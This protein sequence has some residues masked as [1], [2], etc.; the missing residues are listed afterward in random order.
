MSRIITLCSG[1]ARAGKTHLAV[2]LALEMVRRGHNTALFNETGSRS[3]IDD[4]LVL[5]QAAMLQRR[6]SDHGYL[7]VRR[8]YLGVDILS[9]GIPLSQWNCA[10]EQDVSKSIADMDCADGYDDFL[11]D[12]SAMDPCTLLACCRASALV[13]LVV[14]PDIRCHAETF[15]LI[16]ILQLN[17][18]QGELSLLYNKVDQAVD[19]NELHQTFNS[20]LRQYLGLDVPLL[21]MLGN[22]AH[23]S[24]A[25]RARQA[26]TSLFPDAE[27]SNQIVAIA[28][29]IDALGSRAAADEKALPVYWH[30]VRE[31]LASPVALPGGVFLETPDR[32]EDMPALPALQAR[33]FAN[34]VMLLQLDS[35]FHG[36]S[37]TLD[38]LPG[39]LQAT[40]DDVSSL[41]R[42]LEEADDSRRRDD[43]YETRD[44][45]ALLSLVVGLIR[46]VEQAVV[47]NHGLQLQVN[48]NRVRGDDPDWL[49]AGFYLKYIFRF[50]GSE[51]VLSRIRSVLAGVTGFRRETGEQ[52]ETLWEVV[53]ADH[54]GGMNIIHSADDSIRI[55]IWL[56][57]RNRSSLP[58]GS[59]QQIATP[60]LPS[61]KTIH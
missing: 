43:V 35:S 25:E 13:I 7:P 49:Q 57:L 10:P 18:L 2:N 24:R 42:A 9:S 27:V 29:A 52:G 50:P 55:Q 1:L 21:G 28:D 38:S 33:E 58:H 56:P 51:A 47:P 14:T 11:V 59:Q 8:A 17:G 32:T 3:S 39:L 31:M 54:S 15:A 26:F 30:A 61:T 60:T 22:D 23:V 36:F 41:H 6:S 19:V 20:K 46:E 37:D 16:R 12:T 45:D 40:A 34:E 4:L 5:P 48:E 44:S 53:V